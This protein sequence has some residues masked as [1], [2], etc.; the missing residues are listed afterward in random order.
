MH[1]KP[2]EVGWLSYVTISQHANGLS[3]QLLDEEAAKVCLS[4]PFLDLSM[5]IIVSQYRSS[6]S[7]MPED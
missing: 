5:T 3:A 7:D 1:R 2:R 4:P 6:E